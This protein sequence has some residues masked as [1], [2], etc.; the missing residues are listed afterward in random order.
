[1]TELRVN[2]EVE[3][4]K[5][6]AKILG[7]EGDPEATIN[8]ALREVIAVRRRVEAFERLAEMGDAGEFDALADK[9]NYRPR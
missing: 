1:M 8:A 9:K 7:T 2:V 3:A 6:A 4:L 5:A